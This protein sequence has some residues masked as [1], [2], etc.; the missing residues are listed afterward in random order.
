MSEYVR[1]LTRLEREGGGSPVAA[2]QTARPA[3][4]LV[5]V[6]PEARP[7][8]LPVAPAL[9]DGGA[10]A[11]LYDNLRATAGGEGIR[12]LVLAGIVADDAA[13]VVLDGLAAHAG[14]VGLAVRIA[15]IGA[16]HG[17]PVL[18]LR[19]PAPGGAE[20]WLDLRGRA[21][22]TEVRTW[23]ARAEADLILIDGGAVADSIDP[24]LLACGTDGLLLVVRAQGTETAAVAAAVQRARK[25][26]CTVR[27]LVVR[28]PRSAIPPWQRGWPGAPARGES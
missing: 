7:V 12:S 27:G 28:S 25:V 18:R 20:G 5:V 21:N 10:F 16:L 22:A 23:L 8:V 11:R 2:V 9:A 24:A 26:G 13:G 14:Q 3:P 19:Q 1:V 6:N 4:A 15:E 17:R